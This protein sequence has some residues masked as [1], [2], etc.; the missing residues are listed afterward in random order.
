MSQKLQKD[1]SNER[2]FSRR[3]SSY[4]FHRIHSFKDLTALRKSSDSNP[5]SR[6][7][8]SADLL[9][10]AKRSEGW[11]PE[12][13]EEDWQEAS[14]YSEAGLFKPLIKALNKHGYEGA[15]VTYRR[16]EADLTAGIK[17]E[18]WKRTVRIIGKEWQSLEDVLRLVQLEMDFVY[19]DPQK[20]LSGGAIELYT[21]L[22]KPEFGQ[23]SQEI[24][25]FSNEDLK[26]DKPKVYF[27]PHGSHDEVVLKVANS[28][29]G[30]IQKA[31][32]STKEKAAQKLL[33]K[34][35][36]YQ[37]QYKTQP[38]FDIQD[39][40]YFKADDEAPDGD[41]HDK[42][43][44]PHWTALDR[45][46][47]KNIHNGVFVPLFDVT[48]ERFV[49]EKT[50]QRGNLSDLAKEA[51]PA[52]KFTE[53]DAETYKGDNQTA[54]EEKIAKLRQC[55]QTLTNIAC[56]RYSWLSESE[57]HALRAEKPVI[58]KRELDNKT[59]CPSLDVPPNEP[60]K[61]KL[62][63]HD[64]GVGWVRMEKGRKD[65][66]YVVKV[67]HSM[68][69]F[70]KCGATIEDALRRLI[71]HYHYTEVSLSTIDELDEFKN[72]VIWK[73]KILEYKGFGQCRFFFKKKGFTQRHGR[74]ATTSTHS[75]RRQNLSAAMASPNDMTEATVTIKVDHEVK[76]IQY[77]V[78]ETSNTEEGLADKATERLAKLL[79]D[80]AAARKQG[81]AFAFDESIPRWAEFLCWKPRSR[82]SHTSST[83]TSST[84]KSVARQSSTGTS[85]TN[86]SSTSHSRRTE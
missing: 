76:G 6:K 63:W 22:L 50:V 20:H 75:S 30:D 55:I 81:N 26:D 62:R 32:D 25:E 84:S 7:S 74:E 46:R 2:P 44:T 39:V 64:R 79:G 49:Y 4:N 51:I 11:K 54:V 65:K 29:D 56:S 33:R 41:Q 24:F 15:I 1:D 31:R 19:L 59:E 8:S 45:K 42:S 37:F 17:V 27:K 12:T 9:E 69:G 86:A 58:F 21:W 82:V 66:G 73:V 53:L 13:V 47:D 68:F 36:D 28:S 40:D 48:T 67:V 52:I 83:S 34:L 38:H 14:E 10:L 70:A 80:D 60:W 23:S 43:K 5:G 77:K 71:D 61:D 3:I 78:V 35:K 18:H 57:K 16:K 85:T 72:K